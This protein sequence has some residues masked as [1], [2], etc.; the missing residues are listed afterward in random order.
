MTRKCGNEGKDF[1]GNTYQCT[2]NKG[3][4]GYH[5]F[6]ELKIWSTRL[7][8]KPQTYWKTE[9]W[10]NY[11]RYCGKTLLGNSYPCELKPGHKRH[12]KSFVFHKYISWKELTNG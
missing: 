2:R 5:T 10:Y 11:D 6:T 3:H 4:H 7:G 9:S 1:W 12:H 8:Y